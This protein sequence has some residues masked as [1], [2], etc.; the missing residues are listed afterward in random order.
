MR[1]TRI[2]RGA[3][4][5]SY[6]EDLEPPAR[7]TRV[8]AISAWFPAS[9]VLF[10]TVPQGLDLDWHV[11]NDR[12]LIVILEGE[13]EVEVGHGVKRRFGAGAIVLAEDMDGQGHRTTDRV[14]PRR[15]IMIKVPPEFSVEGWRRVEG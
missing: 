1:I 7:E 15:S 2:Y 4:G 12:V 11:A 10:R 13:I 14:G 9:D 6:F 5:V 3:D 8:G